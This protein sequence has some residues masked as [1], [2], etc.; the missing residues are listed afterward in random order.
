MSYYYV[1][2][3][4]CSNELYHHGIIGQKWGV[5][6]FQNK[7]GSLTAEG[8][9]RYGGKESTGEKVKNAVASAGRA[10]G[11]AAK[12][13]GAA[14]GKAAKATVNYAGQQ[15]K[16]SH[17][18]LMTDDELRDYTNRI[19]R[20]KQYSDLLRQQ[21]ANGPGSRARKFV[22][23]ILGEGVK[24]ISRAGFN[25]LSQ[26]MTKSRL[27]RENDEL[28]QKVRKNEL[29]EKLNPKK[30]SG[31]DFAQRIMNDPNASADDIA[32][33]ST[34]LN[35]YRTA[36][37]NIDS[38]FSSDKGSSSTS[39]PS[40]TEKKAAEIIAEVVSPKK[41]SKPLEFDFTDS[42]QNAPAGPQTVYDRTFNSYTPSQKTLE[43]RY[44]GDVSQNV[45]PYQMRPLES[46]VDNTR[47]GSSTRLIAYNPPVERNVIRQLSNPDWLDERNLRNMYRNRR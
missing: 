15:I 47:A 35:N 28:S 24:T 5:R 7:D 25:K 31:L 13:T 4:P 11:S 14:V 36:K 33:A 39:A 2:G 38:L 16:K 46:M 10:V 20:E 41:E 19:M 21:R 8:R 29:L 9:I 44:S 1:A 18:S 17:P 22:G 40:A 43:R 12:K 42:S 27:E 34:V 30:E 37:T 45:T 6:R 23:D 32:K 3:L 26:E